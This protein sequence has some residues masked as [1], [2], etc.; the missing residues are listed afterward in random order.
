VQ[1]TPGWLSH[2]VAA[3]TVPASVTVL[4]TARV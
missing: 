4:D 3:D 2:Q 1:H